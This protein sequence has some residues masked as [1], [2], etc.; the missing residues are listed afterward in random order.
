M[1]DM[2]YVIKRNGKRQRFDENKIRRSIRAAAREARLGDERVRGLV[3]QVS[4]DIIDCAR[5]EKEIRSVTLR[6]SILNELDTAA[7]PAA[8]AWRDFDRKTKGVEC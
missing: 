3:A 5:C 6:A 8:R 4:G 2:T 7:P 1:S